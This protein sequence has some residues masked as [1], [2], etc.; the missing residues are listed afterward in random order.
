MIFEMPSCTGCQTCEMAC[1]FK[2]KGEFKPKSAAIAIDQNN[3]GTGFVISIDRK[4]KD[5]EIDCIGCMEC[6]KT[7]PECDDLKAIIKK[8]LKFKRSHKT[9]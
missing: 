4:E 2:H 6:L 9:S 5:R 1:S 8:F 7:C 3:N